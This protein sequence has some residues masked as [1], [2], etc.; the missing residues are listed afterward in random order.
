MSVKPLLGSYR[1]GTSLLHRLDA[2]VK[3]VCLLAMSVAILAT[4]NPLVLAGFAALV[5]VCLHI[6]GATPR[7][8][9]S[10]LRP[11][12]FLLLFGIVANMF[13]PASA[14]DVALGAVGISFAGLV[15]GVIVA[16]RMVVLIALS[17]VLCATTSSTAVADALCSLLSPLGKLGVPVDDLSTTLSLVLRFV[18]MT[19]EEFGRIREA[20]L[21][22]GANFSQGNVVVRVRRWCA[23]LV[24]LVAGLFRRSGEVACAMRE[25]GWGT[26]PRTR[27]SRKL[28]TTDIMVLVICLAACLAAVLA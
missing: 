28:G 24:P 9:A 15:R 5:L 7:E 8:L 4:G 26:G 10:A 23:A 25:R 16:V 6:S 14:A 13:A 11:A 1:S 2:R 19:A 17:L 18:P 12:A 27:L 21:A 20:Q 3:L 22:R